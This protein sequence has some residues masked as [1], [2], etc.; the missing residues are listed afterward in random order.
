MEI[1]TNLF[2]FYKEMLDVRLPE[3]AEAC[4]EWRIVIHYSSLKWNMPC[5]RHTKSYFDEAATKLCFGVHDLLSTILFHV[6][7]RYNKKIVVTEI[8]LVLLK[9]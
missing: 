6:V 7:Y 5:R 1:I 4:L 9:R 8:A 2:V 3:Q